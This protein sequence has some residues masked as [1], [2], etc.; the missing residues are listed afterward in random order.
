MLS[1]MDELTMTLFLVCRISV[2]AI[3]GT[4]TGAAQLAPGNFN[5]STGGTEI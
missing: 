1:L 5:V 2:I 4:G 3:C